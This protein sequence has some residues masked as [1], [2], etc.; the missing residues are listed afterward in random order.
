MLEIVQESPN[1]KFSPGND[2][3][4]TMIVKNEGNSAMTI[5]LEADVEASGWDVSIGGLSGSPLI[6]IDQFDQATFTVEISVP[7]SANNGQ[8]VPI[9]ITATPLDTEQSFADSMKAQFTL[10]AIVEIASI[11]KIVINEIVHPRPISMV[12]FAVSV[13]LLFAGVQSRLN[14]RRWAA[15]MSMLESLS[16]SEEEELSEVPDIPAPVVVEEQS[17]TVDRYEDDEVELI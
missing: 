1:K 14:R 12:L 5:L 9:S 13:L 17:S 10:V 15:Q 16:D 6:E 4:I 3:S 2:Y 7:T 8:S 11:S